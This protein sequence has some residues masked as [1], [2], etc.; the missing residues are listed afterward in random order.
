MSDNQK[1]HT[2]NRTNYN[3]EWE[4]LFPITENKS[5]K[6][7]FICVPCERKFSCAK[8]LQ[9]VR[10]HCD[11]STHRQNTPG[12]TVG[13][14]IPI[15]TV[16]NLPEFLF[17]QSLPTMAPLNINSN[18][19]KTT[20]NP[21][22][23]STN[24]NTV[25]IK[26]LKNL[27]KPIGTTNPQIKELKFNINTLDKCLNGM[28]LLDKY[29]FAYSLASKMDVDLKLAMGP[30]IHQSP[31]HIMDELHFLHITLQN[32]KKDIK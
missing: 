10:R 12:S 26:N 31:K 18:S 2:R 15:K 21:P 7:S 13:N 11:T 22:Q 5:D 27:K 1:N 4:K 23:P 16:L 8:G 29:K 24:Q 14:N 17:N 9:S 25:D 3:K 6:H 28:N 30:N 19:S 20:Q 32:L